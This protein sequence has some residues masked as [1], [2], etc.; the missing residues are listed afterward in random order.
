MIRTKSVYDDRSEDDGV[1]ILI[2]SEWPRGVDRSDVDDWIPDLAPSDQLE[3]EWNNR[4]IS[5]N[6]FARRYRGEMR[7]KEVQIRYLHDL[8]TRKNVTL[9]CWER[10][11]DRCH[12]KI[13]SEIVKNYNGHM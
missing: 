1:R 13:L 4:K 2:T 3:L 7:E 5:W 8:S 11:D 12:R 6:E 10:S 9:L